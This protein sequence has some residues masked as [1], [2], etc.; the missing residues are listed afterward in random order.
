MTAPAAPTEAG[1]VALAIADGVATIRFSHPKGNSLPGALLRRLADAVREAGAASEARV[2]VLRSEGSGPF[3]AGASFDELRAIR[4]AATGKE[5]FLGFARL[6][7]AM[8][9]CPKFVLVRVHGK[10]VGG[11][12]G[13]AAAADYALAARGASVKLSELAVGIGPF[14]VGPVIEKR[15]GAGP[16]TALAVDAASWRDAAWAERHGLYAG[17]HEG[18]E[19]LD[20]A[21]D[22]LART[23]AASSPEAMAALKRVFW[24]GTEHW[25][26]LLDERAEM[27]GTLVLSTFAREAIER[28]G[29]R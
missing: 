11:G 3:C 12:V 25:D 22:A 29:K 14:V 2:V 15:I 4:D 27:S 20:T 24:E 18:V 10:A 9:A 28:F 26:R 16:F 13:V 21:L 1:H 5:F 6:I 19:E 17:V 8:R 7:L 23:L